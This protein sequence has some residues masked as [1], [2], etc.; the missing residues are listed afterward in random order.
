MAYL[1]RMAYYNNKVAGCLF[2]GGKMWIIPACNTTTR[3]R[4]D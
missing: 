1:F 4:E 3:A 2:G